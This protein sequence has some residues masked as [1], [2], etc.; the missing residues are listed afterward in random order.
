[1]K[2]NV[3]IGSSCHL[4]GSYNVI[5]AFQQLIEENSLHDKVDFKAT[6]CAKQCQN[7]G[8]TVS[9][10]GEKYNVLPEEAREFFKSKVIPNI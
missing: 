2:V 8:V 1:M 4:K 6:F 9:I 3:C 10:D 7:K 5:Q